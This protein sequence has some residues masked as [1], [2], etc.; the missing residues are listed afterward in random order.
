[1]TDVLQ[2]MGRAGRPQFDD[3]GVA[4]ILVHEPK[5][6]F[7]RKFLHEPFPVES[8]LQKQLHNHINAEIVMETIKNKSDCIDYLSWTYFFRRLVIN[9][10]Y[11]GL[12]DV[13][14]EAIQKYLIK[15]IN[16]V[17][18]DLEDNSCVSI[19]DDFTLESTQIGRI[20]SRYYLNYPTL[21]RFSKFIVECKDIAS[22]EEL[23]RVICQADEFAELPVRHNEDTLNADLSVK[24]PWPLTRT[25]AF[26]SPHVKAF[27]LIQAH[28]HKIPLPI[29]DYINDTKTVLDQFPRVLGAITDLS[30]HLKSVQVTRN[31]NKV[32]QMVIPARLLR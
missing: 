12:E 26:D 7:Y 10:S 19:A 22:V 28:L 4:C 20:T 14:N 8:S 2:M 5:K 21:H 13:S 18:K 17:V 23:I 30:V 3:T 16:G 1:M 25:D 24:C 15:L 11:Y 32:G 31:L 6:L 9:P 27:L 29:S